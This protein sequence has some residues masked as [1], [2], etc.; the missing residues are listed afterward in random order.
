MSAQQPQETHLVKLTNVLQAFKPRLAEAFGKTVDVNREI[1][2]VIATVANSAALQKCT[3]KSIAMAAY[4]AA[5]LGLPVNQ[6]GLAYLVPYNGVATL[7]IG[8]RG[9]VKLVSETGLVNS[10]DPYCVYEKDHFDWQCGSNPKVDHK[11]YLKGDPGP[12]IAVYA[13]AQLANGFFKACVMTKSQVDHIKNKSRSGSGGPWFTDYDE[14]AK[15]VVIKR[16]CKTLPLCTNAINAIAQAEAIDNSSENGEQ[17]GAID[18][19]SEEY[20]QESQAAPIVAGVID[21]QAQPT[22]QPKPSPQVNPETNALLSELY[23][24][25]D[26]VRELDEKAEPLPGKVEA[27]APD[28]LRGLIESETAKLKKLR[29][30]LSGK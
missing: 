17:Y 30:A 7:Q 18:I 5:T 3:P 9:Y 8:Y 25:H 23:G 10:I 27:F 22:S 29:K 28:I 24:V 14:M 13:V 19:D 26:A 20:S 12:L 1:G 21:I 6:L 15:K 2:S 16:L 4:T 11:P